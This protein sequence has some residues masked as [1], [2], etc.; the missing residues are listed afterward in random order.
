MRLWTVGRRWTRPPYI[1]SFNAGDLLN[2]DLTGD[3]GP[4]S[5]IYI[6]HSKEVASDKATEWLRK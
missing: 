4:S 2:R 1:P 3:L 6:T 5:S